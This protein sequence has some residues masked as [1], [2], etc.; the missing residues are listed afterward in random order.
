[1]AKADGLEV[2]RF[3]ESN[4][5]LLDADVGAIVAHQDFSINNKEIL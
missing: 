3:L 1:M 4:P 2:D 5:H